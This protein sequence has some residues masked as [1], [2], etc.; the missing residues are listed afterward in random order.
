ME[1]TNKNTRI[2]ITLTQEE[3]MRE[4]SMFMEKAVWKAPKN[5][6]IGERAVVLHGYDG[7]ENDAH[8]CDV[9]CGDTTV[10]EIR[11]N[12]TVVLAN[13]YKFHADGTGYADNKAMVLSDR[14]A[15]DRDKNGDP[16]FDEEGR[17]TPA[18]KK[19][20]YTTF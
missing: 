20:H 11:K 16:V 7:K 17:N 2:K 12:G 4:Y 9:S 8:F 14:H 19:G 1:T 5:L 15:I 3:E 6:K 10:V 13:G 18:R